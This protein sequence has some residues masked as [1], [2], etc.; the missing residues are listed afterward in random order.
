MENDNPPPPGLDEDLAR[1]AEAATDRE[2]DAPPP[3]VPSDG[4]FWQGLDRVGPYLGY[5]AAGL[6]LLAFL[7]ALLGGESF[8]WISFLSLPVL[9][10]LLLYIAYLV[11]RRL[12]EQAA[13][14]LLNHQRQEQ[15]RLEVA[16]QVL[17]QRKRENDSH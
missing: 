16:R 14:Y 8:A 17:E 15:A 10:L 11:R 2:D 12:Q 5:T 6:T 13:A 7:L 3:P 1:L 4:L 9:I